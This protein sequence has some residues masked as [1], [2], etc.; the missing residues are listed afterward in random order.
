MAPGEATA[1]GSRLTTGSTPAHATTAPGRAPGATPAYGAGAPPAYRPGAFE[2]SPASGASPA[3]GGQSGGGRRRV[4]I[5][6]LVAAV[7]GAQVAATV[8]AVVLAGDDDSVAARPP[9][10]TPDGAMDVRA[11]LGQVQESVVT[12]ETSVNSQ[13]GVF[14]GAGTGVVLSADGLI[15]TNSHVIAQSDGITVRAFDGAEYEATLV[16]SEPSNDLAVIRVDGADDLVPAELGSSE[17][18]LVGEPVIAIGNALNLGGQPSVTTGIVSA[19]N[20]TIDSP[21]GQLSDLIQTDAAINPG[22]SGGPL[23]D[24]SGAVVGINTAIIEDSQNIGFSIAIDSAKPI[25]EELQQGNGEIT[26]DTPRLGVTTVPVDTVA[27]EVREQ[28]DIQSETG[29]FVVDVVPDSGA[30][31]A[32]VEQGDVIVSVDGEDITSNEQLGQIVRDSEPGDTIEIVVE[33]EGE[34]QTLTAEIGRQGG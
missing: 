34:E 15:M 3:H 21:D 2:P 25:I 28:F 6:A 10:M 29:A 27:D 14:E 31:E 26:P 33:R 11:I 1:G 16:G 24:S 9:V 4:W 30:D 19:T 8:G 7:A 20:R 23:V 18:L 32:G 17:A 13:G 5:V 22:N 12:I